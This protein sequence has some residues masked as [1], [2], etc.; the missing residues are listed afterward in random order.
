MQTLSPWLLSWRCC[1][2]LACLFVLVQQ[3]ALVYVQESSLDAAGAS[4]SGDNNRPLPTSDLTTSPSTGPSSGLLREDGPLLLFD[5]LS[6]TERNVLLRVILASHRA[7]ALTPAEIDQLKTLRLFSARNLSAPAVGLT[8]SGGSSTSSSAVAIKDCLSGAFWC[9][10]ESVLEGVLMSHVQGHQRSTPAPAHVTGGGAVSSTMRSVVGTLGQGLGLGSSHS[11]AGDAPLALAQAPVV[12]LHDAALVDLYTLLGVAEL[13][14][15][16]A[17]RR[18]TLP[19]LVNPHLPGPERLSAMLALAPK[20]RVYRADTDLVTTLKEV[21]WVPAWDSG[22]GTRASPSPSLDTILDPSHHCHQGSV[23]PEYRR[24]DQLLSWINTELLEALRGPQ[25]SRYFAPPVPFHASRPPPANSGS[26]DNNHHTTVAAGNGGGVVGVLSSMGSGG[27]SGDSSSSNPSGDSLYSML[28]DLGM[29]P[30]LTSDYLVRIAS[31][32]EASATGGDTSS[33]DSSGIN[34][35]SQQPPAPLS[36]PLSLLQ[37]ARDRGRRL[38]RYL[39][40]LGGMGTPGSTIITTTTDLFTNDLCRRL[41]RITFVPVERPTAVELGGHVVYEASLGCFDQL[42]ALHAGTGTGAGASGALGFTVMPL[43]E[44]DL[45]PPQIFFSSL[46]VT[47]QPPLEVVLRHI[48]NLTSCGDSLDRWNTQHFSL[49]ET[50]SALFVYLAEHWREVAPN[51]KDAL[52]AAQLVPVGHSLVRPS[53]LFFRLAGEDFSPFMHEM[54]RY[55]LHLTLAN[56]NLLLT[57]PNLTL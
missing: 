38:L 1:R 26:A 23:A 3:N 6:V 14:A 21:A 31:D 16:A 44:A 27:S 2:L 48:R 25:Q 36:E 12:L 11:P 39:T 55:E 54:P 57:Y 50:F 15:A 45:A 32:I 41:R 42:L 13:T 40:K 34:T 7:L 8:S 20:W 46:G 24:P 47:S 37:Q 30:D 10:S 53:R 33:S 18:F 52:R 22:T 28:T 49:R 35:S 56:K 9:A 19:S 4:A 29:A 17:V 43:L 51:V 5:L